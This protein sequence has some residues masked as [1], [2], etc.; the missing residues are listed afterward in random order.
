MKDILCFIGVC[1]FI[2]ITA[3]SLINYFFETEYSMKH[4]SISWW[5]S[6][7][8]KRIEVLEKKA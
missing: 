8:E 7:L 4:I 6:D 1:I 5:I 3:L 2:M